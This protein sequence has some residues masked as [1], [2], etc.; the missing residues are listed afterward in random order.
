MKTLIDS[1]I[2]IDVLSDSSHASS[3]IEVIKK[4]SIK[5]N[6]VVNQVV[7]SEVAPEFSSVKDQIAF[8]DGIECMQVSIPFEAARLAGTAHFKYRKL[9]GSR[10][11]T[12]PDFLMGAHAQ[13]SEMRI[14]TRDMAVYTHYFPQIEIISPGDGL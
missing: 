10:T 6:L 2:V 5:G 7:W 13:V 1:N 4:E 11:R 8:F 3:S 12:L 9:G 14:L